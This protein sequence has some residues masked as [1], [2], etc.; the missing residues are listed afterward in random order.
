M[1]LFQFRAFRNAFTAILLCASCPEAAFAEKYGELSLYV[2]PAYPVHMNWESPRKLFL[3]SI[4][5]SLF[6]GALTI[7]H[8]SVGVNCGMEDESSTPSTQ[9]LSGAVPV[10]GSTA[11]RLL[12]TRKVGLSLLE[13]SW[14]GT[15]ESAESV[16]NSFKITNGKPKRMSV[17]TFLIPESSC[18]RLVQ[19]FKEYS[20]TPN[21]Y[22]GNSP[23]PRRKEGAGC[24]AFGVSFLEVAGIMNEEFAREWAVTVRVPQTL[25]AGYLGKSKVRNREILGS[26][27]SREW[28]RES[29]P[30]MKL[31]TFEPYL[32]HQWVMK[33]M[34]SP[35]TMR[36][37]GGE[38]TDRLPY[39][40]H[41]LHA[42]RFDRRSVPTP[43]EPIFTGPRSLIPTSDLTVIRA[44]KKFT[45][46]GSFELHP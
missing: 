42:I 17:I 14:A 38:V 33:L 2:M 11:A 26:S 23:R 39:G 25:M 12:L 37:L 15:T 3:S 18:Q 45:S 4:K 40:L 44:D 29:D 31:T 36:A 20:A 21:L 1:M 7:G 34:E 19:Y 13:G 30:H 16:K 32:M 9:I 43:V 24:T 28:A 46:E 6:N 27:F 41:G 5:G 8:V 10:S 35:E 22:Y